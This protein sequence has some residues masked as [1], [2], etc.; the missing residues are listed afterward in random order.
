MTPYLA[1]YEYR[2]VTVRGLERRTEGASNWEMVTGDEFEQMTA[3]E[4]RKIADTLDAANKDT[5]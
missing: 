2:Y 5:D 4:L 1:R 3:S